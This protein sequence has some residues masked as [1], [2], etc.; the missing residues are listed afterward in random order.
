M[1]CVFG[2]LCKKSGSQVLCFLEK[3]TKYFETE[4][5]VQRLNSVLF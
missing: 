2:K 1:N 5:I 4:E 3:L